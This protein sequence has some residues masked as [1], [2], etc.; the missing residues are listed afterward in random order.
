[1]N[2]GRI[3]TTTIGDNENKQDGF[4]LVVTA[5]SM[6][7]LVL[8]M[9]FG[10]DLGSWYL[11]ASKLQRAS[12]A[13]ALAGAAKLPDTN[14]AQAAITDAYDHNGFVDGANGIKINWNITSDG[15]AT[16]ITNQSVPTYFA[17]MVLPHLAI[18]R[19]SYSMST[20]AP[21][22][23]SPYNVLG[24]GNLSI[25]GL[26][27]AQ[28]FWLAINGI[29][30]PKEDGDY[31]TARYD[32]S[33]G[34]FTT[35]LDARND[36][37]PASTGRTHCPDPRKPSAYPENPD[38]ESNGYSYF[39][40]IPK[41]PSG[42]GT[43]SIEIYDPAMNSSLPDYVD[44]MPGDQV[45]AW[46][47]FAF[48]LFNTNGTPGNPNDDTEVLPHPFALYADDKRIGSHTWWTLYTIPAASIPN[49]GQFRVEALPLEDYPNVDYNKP[50]FEAANRGVDAFSIGA[51]ASWESNGSIHAC[52]ADT[53]INCPRVYAL[54]SESIF[55][56][57]S[58]RATGGHVDILLASITPQFVGQTFNLMLWDPGEGTQGIQLVEPNG[59]PIPFTYT[60]SG[61]FPGDVGPSSNSA[62][63]TLD[64]SSTDT[65]AIV[66]GTPT[67]S[68]D[69]TFNDR[70]V[71]LTFTIPS[72]YEANTVGA[73]NWMRLR[74][75]VSS[76]SPNDRTTWGL[77]AYGS[78]G[79]GPVHL[80]PPVP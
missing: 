34:P 49:G 42:T 16:S 47:N 40:D 53:D 37:V 29:C 74:Y 52:N 58:G 60:S 72:S 15:V 18:T 2:L 67:L 55:N 41:S 78:T 23:G 75:V 9:G 35:A 5:I 4:V 12:D 8:L 20:P 70:L 43:V 3:R 14:A 36:Y 61:S 24:T 6:V 32:H 33:K 39:V 7:A 56:N 10:V 28:N 57:L 46:G 27:N 48:D 50:A 11:N 21:I 79:G 73:D 64:T 66:N 63:T 51:F 62:V 77:S 19:T 80:T 13:A 71:T 54:N 59:T 44:D 17:R 31:F 26:P 22:L 69:Y 38:Y 45:T 68:N 25:P 1:M 30:S 65:H 76:S